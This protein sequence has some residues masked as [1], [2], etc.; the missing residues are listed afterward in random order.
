MP[1][2]APDDEAP[3][4][5]TKT[6]NRKDNMKERA[7]KAVSLRHDNNRPDIY[8]AL[9]YAR[10]QKEDRLPSNCDTLIFENM[11]RIF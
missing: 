9:H 10:I 1:N 8:T 6:S 5:T 4:G 3:V 7:A 2:D 11:D